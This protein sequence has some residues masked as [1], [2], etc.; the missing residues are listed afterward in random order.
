M[1]SGEGR[2]RLRKIAGKLREIAM[3]CEIAENC[4]KLRTPPPRGEERN[5]GDGG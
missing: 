5:G 3:N 2:I 4:E 1:P